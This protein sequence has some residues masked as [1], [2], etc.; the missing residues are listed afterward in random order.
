MIKFG[1]VLEDSTVVW[2]YKN[3]QEKL[4]SEDWQNLADN[5]KTMLIG[6]KEKLALKKKAFEKIL[7]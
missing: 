6:K 5:E 4:T 2:H 1:L 7:K 3:T